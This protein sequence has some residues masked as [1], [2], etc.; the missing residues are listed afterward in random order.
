M[1]AGQG[2]LYLESAYLQFL[3]MLTYSAPSP[4]EGVAGRTSCFSA[5]LHG[6]ECCTQ[7]P[8]GKGTWGALQCSHG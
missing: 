3:T 8:H 5:A 4:H 2:A 7:L 1:A 6:T